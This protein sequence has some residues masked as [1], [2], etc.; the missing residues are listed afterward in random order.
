MLHWLLGNSLYYICRDRCRPCAANSGLGSGRLGKRT[1]A[2]TLQADVLVT[3]RHQALHGEAFP[4]IQSQRA[5][6]E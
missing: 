3:E 6:E 5:A 4:R 2:S 1:G